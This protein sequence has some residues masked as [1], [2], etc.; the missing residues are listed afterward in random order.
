M[1][2]G[3]RSKSHTLGVWMNGEFVGRWT[4]NSRGDHEFAYDPAWVTS[5]YGRS[6]S[7]SMPLQ[8]LTRFRGAVVKNYFDN[9]LPDNEQIR[10]R[11]QQRFGT[12]ST[13]PFD[14]LTEIGRDCVGALQLLPEGEAPGDVRRIDVEPLAE[15]Q[16]E[17][18]LSVAPALGRH[19]EADDFRISI[20]GAQEKT[21]LT[22]NSGRWGRP[23]GSTPTTHILKLPIG[24]HHDHGIDLT[25]S[26]ENEWLCA[27]ILQAYGVE[28]S[29][30]WPETFG[31]KTVLVV[32]RFDRRLSADGRWLIRLPQED[33]CQAMGIPPAMKYERDGGPGIRAIMDLLL[34]SSEADADRRSFYRTQVIFWML[35][36]IDGHAKNFS[37]FLERGGGYRLTPRYDV[38][39]AYPVLGNGPRLLQERK[40]R[41]AM[42]L[43]GKNRHYRWCELQRRHLDS[44]AKFCGLAESGSA[45]VEDLI[46]MT[47]AVVESVAA[48][49]PPGF[50]EQ[51]SRPI[52]QGLAASAHRLETVINGP[53]D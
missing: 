29:K 25:T 46:A 15:A 26:V 34:G 14:L 4:V 33:L 43:V 51:V 39:S 30:C 32:E 35:C 50:P 3:R 52:L 49:L 17:K 41:M 22:L 8:P 36:A 5:E 42:A 45:I 23:R 13:T 2:V 37:V 31:S 6:I 1:S 40:V 20:A 47:S 16:I 28:T 53:S 10:T 9:L 18:L 21:A 44:T 11:I 27:R 48:E 19:E 12:Q 38:L 7:L 24:H